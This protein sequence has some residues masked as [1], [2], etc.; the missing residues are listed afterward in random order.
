MGV[1]TNVIILGAGQGG[2]SLIEIFRNDPL[3]KIIGI[4]EVNS[5]APG[6][7]LARQLK[8]PITSDYRKLLK[9]KR[10][11]LLIDVTGDLEVE[12]VLL[13]LRR[14]GVAVIGGPSAKFMWQLIEERI[15]SKEAIERHLSEY[16]ALY[17]LYVKEVSLAVLEERAQ[18]AWE[19]HDG[20][21]QTLVGLTFKM[22]HCQ[23]LLETD[24]TQSK[25]QLEEGRRHL[26]GAIQEARQV[27]F[28]L[29]PLSFDHMELLPALKNYL[30]SYEHQ[31]KIKTSLQTL[32]SEKKIFP[33]SKIVIF[34]IIQ[35]ALS[36]IQK[37]SKAKQVK[38]SLK[39]DRKVLRVAISD[40]G[41]GFDPHRVAEDPEKWNSFGL[42]G[43]TERAKLLGGTSQVES[44]LG[45]GTRILVQIPLDDRRSKLFEEN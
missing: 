30:R 24:P 39:V 6:L 14:P 15:R 16:Q 25:K 20:L 23:E 17:R 26:R 10:V 35:E 22:D 34:R 12:R 31:Y 7:K 41:V 3:V 29:K 27:I 21:V 28:N 36:N 40:D 11:D 13:E 4:A 18:I 19:I 33:K 5:K 2:T 32:G 37:H 43:I 1:V 42:K 44:S 8:I 9:S 45:E 38:I